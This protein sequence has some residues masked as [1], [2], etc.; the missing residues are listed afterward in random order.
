[1]QLTVTLTDDRIARA[2]FAGPSAK[3]EKYER[4]N[5]TIDAAPSFVVA[6]VLRAIADDVDPSAIAFQQVTP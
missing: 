6:G 5:I 2:Q 3:P 4:V 1:M